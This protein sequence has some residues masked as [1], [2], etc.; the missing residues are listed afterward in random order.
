[1]FCENHYQSSTGGPLLFDRP[2]GTTIQVGITGYGPPGCSILNF[3]DVKSRVSAQIDWI[4]K[5]ACSEVGDLCPMS[6]SGKSS[7]SSKSGKSSTSSPTDDM[8]GSKSGKSGVA[9][10]HTIEDVT[11]TLGEL[12]FLVSSMSMSMQN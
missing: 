5:N 3:P 2:D 11:E 1:M 12:D 4:R 10:I 6:K 7:T 9:P 8:L